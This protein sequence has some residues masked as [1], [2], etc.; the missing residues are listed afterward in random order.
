MKNHLSFLDAQRQFPLAMV[1]SSQFSFGG[2]LF[3]CHHQSLRFRWTNP[4]PSLCMWASQAVFF[5]FG[6]V[7][8]L[9]LCEGFL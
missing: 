7:G 8:S 9:F 2:P 6:C 5:F 1:T 4:F 3:L